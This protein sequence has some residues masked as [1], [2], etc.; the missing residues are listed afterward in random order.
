M[1]NIYI[2]ITFFTSL[3]PLWS[4]IDPSLMIILT[5]NRFKTNAEKVKSLADAVK[6][7]NGKG[8]IW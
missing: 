3:H 7:F 2:E 1:R 8:K 5:Q 6:K 4:L